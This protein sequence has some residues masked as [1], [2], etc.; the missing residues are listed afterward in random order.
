VA[1]FIRYIEANPQYGS[2]PPVDGIF[3]A[4]VDKWPCAG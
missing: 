4:L 1:V 3:R 2:E